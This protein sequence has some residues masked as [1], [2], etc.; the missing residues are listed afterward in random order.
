MRF[1][2]QF[3]YILESGLISGKQDD[4]ISPVL[5][6]IY[7]AV[8][9]PCVFIR[10]EITLYTI[11]DLDIG[12]VLGKLASGFCSIRKTLNDAVVSYSDCRLSS[13]SSIIDDVLYFVETVVVTHLGVAVK[14]NTSSV[15]ISVFLE[16]LLD[17]LD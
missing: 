12:A 1:A 9:K 11:D 7:S 10:I 16:S 13:A 17:G 6:Y 4:V 8:L 5:L 14:L 3:V 15:R 2:Y